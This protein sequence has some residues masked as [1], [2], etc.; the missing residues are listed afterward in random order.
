MAELQPEVTLPVSAELATF[1][2]DLSEVVS[3][4]HMFET[5]LDSLS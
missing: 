4:V 3:V 2:A 1:P 5:P